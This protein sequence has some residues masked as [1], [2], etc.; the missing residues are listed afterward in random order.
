MSTPTPSFP[1]ENSEAL[2]KAILDE[3]S[4]ITAPVFSKVLQEAKQNHM[5]VGGVGSRRARF[6]YLQPHNYRLYFDFDASG[7]VFDEDVSS[8]SKPPVGNRPRGFLFPVERKVINQSEHFIRFENFTIRVKKRQVEVLNLFEHKKLYAVDLD[9][10]TDAQIFEIASIKNRQC[11]GFLRGFIGQYG[12]KSSGKVLRASLEIKHFDERLEPLLPERAR[13]NNE[14]MKKV[15]NERVVET[16]DWL[17][18]SNLLKNQALQDLTPVLA[19]ELKAIKERLPKPEPELVWPEL[20]APWVVWR[21][22]YFDNR[23]R[24]NWDFSKVM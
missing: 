5:M 22:F 12:G 10:P 24:L 14:A 15:Y 9:K 19:D 18:T 11:L 16:K 20:S 6:V 17:F 1:V 4:R 7:F 13:W 2:D 21:A 8:F 23:V 3:V